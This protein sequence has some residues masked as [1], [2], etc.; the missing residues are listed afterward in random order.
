MPLEKVVFYYEKLNIYKNRAKEKSKCIR[1]FF[2]YHL[3]MYIKIYS[4]ELN[5]NKY[6]C[7]KKKINRQVLGGM[8]GAALIQNGNPLVLHYV[9]FIPTIM[10]QG[11]IEQQGYWISRAWSCNIIGTYAQV[12]FIIYFLLYQSQNIFIHTNNYNNKYF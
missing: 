2:Y 9:M 8:L 1:K 5:N 11:T 10:G 12:K 6:C 3:F 4:Y 7:W